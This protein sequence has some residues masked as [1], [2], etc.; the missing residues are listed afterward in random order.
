MLWVRDYDYRCGEKERFGPTEVSLEDGWELARDFLN[1]GVRLDL[2]PEDSRYDAVFRCW[3]R[4]ECLEV[5]MGEGT[6]VG[7]G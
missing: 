3:R 5:G 6:R 2:S 7:E 4:G 1:S